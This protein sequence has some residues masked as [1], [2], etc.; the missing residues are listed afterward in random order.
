MRVDLAVAPRNVDRADAHTCFRV[1]DGSDV[2]QGPLRACAGPSFHSTS[3]SIHTLP[4]SAY[5]SFSLSHFRL[6]FVLDKT[7][8]AGE[9][10]QRQAQG[11]RVDA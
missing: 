9:H 1:G 6:I 11:T 5:R 10:E 4:N 2:E 7:W 3:P 8:E